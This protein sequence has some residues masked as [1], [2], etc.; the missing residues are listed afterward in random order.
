MASKPG[1]SGVREVHGIGLGLLG[2]FGLRAAE[3]DLPDRWP[4]RRS[5]TGPQAFPGGTGQA[6]VSSILGPLIASVSP[7][8]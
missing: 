4:I 1:G 8:R 2:T 6:L 3:A 5:L 7:A